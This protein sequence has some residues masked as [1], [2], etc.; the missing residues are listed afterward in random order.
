MRKLFMVP[1]YKFP[2]QQEADMRFAQTFRISFIFHVTMTRQSEMLQRPMTMQY[3]SLE[4]CG[5]CVCK[6]IRNTHRVSADYVIVEAAGS[7]SPCGGNA[8]SLQGFGEYAPPFF[9]SMPK[10]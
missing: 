5:L 4:Y 7:I 1:K 10:V 2:F 9:R 3:F 6:H 8:C